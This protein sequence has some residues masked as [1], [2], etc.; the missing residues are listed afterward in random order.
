MCRVSGA[1]KYDGDVEEDWWVYWLA[2]SDEVGS[3]SA[4]CILDDLGLSVRLVTTLYEVMK[5][6]SVTNKVIKRLMPKPSKVTCVLC[7]LEKAKLHTSSIMP[8][9]SPA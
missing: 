4:Y 8:G 9:K 3:R 7:G 6:T 5:P 2:A 1:Y